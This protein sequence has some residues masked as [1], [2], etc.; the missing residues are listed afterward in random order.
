MSVDD[1]VIS[2]KGV[3]KLLRGLNPSKSSGLDELHPTAFKELAIE[4]ACVGHVFQ[5][6]IVTSKLHRGWSVG[7]IS[8][9]IREV[10]Q[11]VSAISPTLFVM[12]TF[13]VVKTYITSW[14]ILRNIKLTFD[15]NMRLGKNIVIYSAYHCYMRLQQNIWQ[16]RSSWPIH[17]ATNLLHLLINFWHSNCLDIT[18]VERI[19]IWTDFFS[20]LRAEASCH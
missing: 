4:E 3:T 16:R 20:K 12:R 7:N 8:A 9:S 10:T 2:A 1:T 17:I 6:F 5:Q 13:Q 11:L 19:L 14:P 18:L 15:R